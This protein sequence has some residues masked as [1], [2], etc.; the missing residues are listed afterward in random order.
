MSIKGKSLIS[1]NDLSGEDIEA[2]FQ[3]ARLFGG[4]QKERLPILDALESKKSLE[5]QKAFLFFAEPSTRT[6]ISFE[7]ACC[8][9]GITPIVFSDAKSSSMTKGE[10]LEETLAT[11]QHFDP[12]VIILRYKSSRIHFES[13]IPIVNA[14]FG[15][16]EHPTQALIDA[17]TIKE[18]R[19]QVKGEKVLIVGDALHSRVSNS[20]LKLL[21]RM[22]AEVA[23]CSP[24]SLLPKGDLWKGVKRFESLN[25]GVEWASVIM[26]LRI[27]QERHDMSIGLSIAEYRDCYHFGPKQLEILRKDS[28]ILHPG[29]YICGVEIDAEVLKDPRSRIMEQ[30]RHSPA[31]RAAALSLILGLETKK[32]PAAG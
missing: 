12:S 23:F 13:S 28:A 30:V 1:V 27:Q 6:R 4:L 5:G 22:G 32:Q 11:L 8:S 14:G 15:S 10:G 9:L 24:R 25:E 17:F 7:L 19:G 2:V 3:R 18:A 26:C 20:N 16:Y 21:R 31:I 29:P